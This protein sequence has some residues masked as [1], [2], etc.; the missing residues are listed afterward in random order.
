MELQEIKV[1]DVV[2]LKSEEIN[3]TY[4]T[5]VE[6]IDKKAKCFWKDSQDFKTYDIPLPALCLK[7]NESRIKSDSL[8]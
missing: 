5:V 8:L 3:P 7:G 2:R 4:M 6:I 1:G